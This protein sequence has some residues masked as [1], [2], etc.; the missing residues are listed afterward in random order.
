MLPLVLCLLAVLGLCVALAY[1]SRTASS[2]DSQPSQPAPLYR[3]FTD[4]SQLHAAELTEAIFSRR[5][6][7][8]I[9]REGSPELEKLFLAERRAVASYWITV[10]SSRVSEVRKNHF[11]NSR[12]SHDLSPDQEL[13]LLVQFLYLF[14]ICR[15]GLLT[16]QLAGPT[17]PATLAAHIQRIVSSL[18]VL[19]GGTYSRVH[20][21]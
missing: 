12:F 19:H 9:R 17:A 6:W 21:N 1:F 11:I 18:P 16:V 7:D 5:D 4:R 13:R 20:E 3:D 2:E 10:T 15:V 8:F 14:V